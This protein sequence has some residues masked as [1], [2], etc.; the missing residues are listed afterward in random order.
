MSPFVGVLRVGGRLDKKK[1]GGRDCSHHPVIM[2]KNHYVTKL[3]VRRFNHQG[4]HQERLL[5]ES[6]IRTDGFWVVGAKNL[7]RS[8]IRS[9]VTC[10]KLQGSFGWQKMAD[11]PVDRHQ[12][13]PPFSY[14]G[15]DT[16]GPW[17]TTQRRTR[18]GTVNQKRWAFMFTCLVSRAVHLEAIEELCTSSLIN[19]LRGFTALRGQ[20]IKFRS[21]D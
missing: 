17:I 18:G 7:V 13:A 21:R 1:L 10:R 15:V 14:V 6:A 9:C 3:L 5:T 19:A 12:P 4:L 11:L 8:E 20:V 2:R 16:F